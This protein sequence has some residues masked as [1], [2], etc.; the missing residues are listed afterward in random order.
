LDGSLIRR[1]DVPAAYLKDLTQRRKEVDP[2][3]KE[4]KR[5]LR[6]GDVVGAI[7]AL[8][9]I[10]EENPGRSD[11]LRL[12]GYRLIDLGRSAQA[13]RLFDEVRKQRPF[14]PHSY[15]DLARSLEDCGKYALAA[16]NYEIALAGTWH[17][18]FGDSLKAVVREEYTRSLREAI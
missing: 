6:S 1:E 18:R 11:A 16:V 14:E 7:R 8:S 13:A 2:F 4:A 10:I 12:V 9:S 15:R 17:G 3:V 5:R